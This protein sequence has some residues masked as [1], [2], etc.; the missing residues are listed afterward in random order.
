MDLWR[1]ASIIVHH[2]GALR[3]SLQAE[4][5]IRL[6]PHGGGR[7]EPHRS[8]RELADLVEHLPPGCALAREMGG[9][10]ALSNEALMGREIEFTIRS[11]A[12][13]LTG[14][15]GKAPERIPLPRAAHEERAEQAEMSAKARRWKARQDRSQSD[16]S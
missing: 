7:T 8:P 11:V 10:A 5:G 6:L 15:K 13:G 1:L 16:R 9:A 4:Y 2:E 12:Y 14:G 3:A